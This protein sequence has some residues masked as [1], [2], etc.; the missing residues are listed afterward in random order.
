[1]REGEYRKLLGDMLKMVLPDCKREMIEL[2][3]WEMVRQK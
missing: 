3:D 2:E 1:M